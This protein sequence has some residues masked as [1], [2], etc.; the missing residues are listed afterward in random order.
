MQL[1]LINKIWIFKQCYSVCVCFK[2]IYVLSLQKRK[3]LAVIGGKEKLRQGLS[4]LLLCGMC[5]GSKAVWS[6][7]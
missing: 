1:A 2:N 5:G 6:G 3:D 4:F 7:E